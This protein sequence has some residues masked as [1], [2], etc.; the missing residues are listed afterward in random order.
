M[1]P[2]CCQP[3]T[4]SKMLNP[5]Q[6]LICLSTSNLQSE[7]GR[8]GGGLGGLK[9]IC[10]IWLGNYKNYILIISRKIACKS[11]IDN[12]YRGLL[13]G[14]GFGSCEALGATLTLCTRCCDVTAKIKKKKKQFCPHRSLVC[15]QTS[16]KAYILWSSLFN[17]KLNCLVISK[18]HKNHKWPFLWVTSWNSDAVC[19]AK[20]K[21]FAFCS[22][23][24]KISF[25]C[26]W[27]R[28]PPFRD[29]VEVVICLGR[30][31]PRSEIFFIQLP[32]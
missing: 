6:V 4:T 12:F 3:D 15:A 24:N 27:R 10:F 31:I 17:T 30:W 5:I 23:G 11:C 20:T 25:W 32:K 18:K 8:E 21:R 2:E 26:W 16:R 22:V 9:F 13:S 7:G 29:V 1:V 19:R 14:A 28:V